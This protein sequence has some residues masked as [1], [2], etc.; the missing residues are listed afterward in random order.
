[1]FKGIAG[2]N[3]RP[4]CRW[5]EFLVRVTGGLK[6]ANIRIDSVCGSVLEP[7]E[8]LVKV[9]LDVGHNPAAVSALM[10][11]VKKQ[12]IDQGAA[13]R[14]VYA[15]SKDKNIQECVRAIV[16]NVPPDRVH[17]AKSTNWRAASH[18]ELHRVF[19]EETGGLGV[20]DLGEDCV[21]PSDTIK[22]GFFVC[23]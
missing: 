2:C 13:V 19:K 6:I 21:N 14:V 15:V 23:L 12:F 10:K 16:K 20:T 11:R 18:E 8:G 1:M 3:L 7:K 5:E 9:I 17:F 4:P 22:R